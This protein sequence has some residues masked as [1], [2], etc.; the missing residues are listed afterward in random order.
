VWNKIVVQL[1]SK[2]V[3]KFQSWKKVIVSI[4]EENQSDIG[5]QSYRIERLDST[6]M[7][8][9]MPDLM[10]V[11][12]GLSIGPRAVMSVFPLSSGSVV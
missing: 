2:I 8:E 3:V 7:V 10:T 12:G 11:S 1:W 6:T 4:V 5:S 9:G